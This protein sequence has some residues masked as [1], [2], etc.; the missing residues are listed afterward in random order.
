MTKGYLI[1]E[2]YMGYIDGHYMLFATE[3]EYYDYI[4][5]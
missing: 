3:S 1:Y 4:E 5:N 2:G